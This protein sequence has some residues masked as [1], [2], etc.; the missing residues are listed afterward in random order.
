VDAL[1]R[2]QQV[3]L[4]ERDERERS[5]QHHPANLCGEDKTKGRGRG[6]GGKQAGKH[7][8]NPCY[9]HDFTTI[10][11]SSISANHR[12]HNHRTQKH[13]TSC[14]FAYI[15]VAQYMHACTIHIHT[16]TAVHAYCY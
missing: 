11:K 2:P 4:H 5:D 10:M 15:L 7:S 14:T 6:G 1:A 8:I 12:A 13:Y 16:A 3:G 9:S